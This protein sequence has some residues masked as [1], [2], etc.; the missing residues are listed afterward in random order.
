MHPTPSHHGAELVLHLNN[1]RPVRATEFARVLRDL[2]TDYKRLYRDELIIV[3]V[4][5]G[6]LRARLKSASKAAEHANHILDFGIKLAKLAGLVVGVSA[7]IGYLNAQSDE[8]YKSMQS[9]SKLAADSRSE[10]ELRYVTPDKTEVLV[11]VTPEQAR[12]VETVLKARLAKESAPLK[13]LGHSTLKAL[14]GPQTRL[15]G[16][17]DLKERLTG[18][19]PHGG[20]ESLPDEA[21][22]LIVA[23]VLALHESAPFRVQQLL[24][25]LDAEHHYAAAEWVR[26][27]ISDHSRPDPLRG[28]ITP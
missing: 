28:Q 17:E 22:A 3:G 13:E 4:P 9:L 11:T 26:K 14:P 7:G 6:S 18:L 19:G 23:V 25:E 16:Y 24:Y 2:A 10:L 1:D 27:I 20:L 15:A 21:Q 12:T 8:P 5:E